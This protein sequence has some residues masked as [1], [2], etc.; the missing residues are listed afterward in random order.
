MAAGAFSVS[1]YGNSGNLGAYSINVFPIIDANGD[2]EGNGGYCGNDELPWQVIRGRDIQQ[3]SLRREKRNI[4]E[5]SGNAIELLESTKVVTYANKTDKNNEQRI[6]FIADD[7]PVELTGTKH[8]AMQ[9]GNCIGVLIKAVQELAEKNNKLKNE[10]E[11]IKE[12][13]NNG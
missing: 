13:L 6:G 8:N 3:V 7:T 2:Y 11:K 12:G 10:I 5:Y 9:I 1:C 4:Q